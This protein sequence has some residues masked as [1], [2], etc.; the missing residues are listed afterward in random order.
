MKAISHFLFHSLIVSILLSYRLSNDESQY[1]VMAFMSVPNM[2]NPSIWNKETSGIGSSRGIFWNPLKAEETGSGGD[3]NNEKNNEA[4]YRANETQQKEQEM[5]TAEVKRKL[6]LEQKMRSKEVKKKEIEVQ[7]WRTKEQ[8]IRELKEQR[9]IEIKRLKFQLTALQESLAKT[10]K[11]AKE[12]KIQYDKLKKN[13]SAKESTDREI[14]DELQKKFAREEELLKSQIKV[15]E[16]DVMDSNSRFEKSESSFRKKE[17][18]LKSEID[19]LQGL[20]DKINRQFSEA[21]AKLLSQKQDFEGKLSKQ[22]EDAD[23]KTKAFETASGMDKRG[24]R[25]E[26]WEA[27]NKLEVVKYELNVANRDMK[28][29]R[30]TSEA[31]EKQVNEMNKEFQDKLFELETRM[32]GDQMSFAKA[33]KAAEENLESVKAEFKTKLRNKDKEFGDKLNNT[34]LEYEQKLEEMNETLSSQTE[35]IKKLKDDEIARITSETAA[36]ITAQE[37]EF[38]FYKEK[39]EETLFEEKARSEKEVADLKNEMERK[40]EWVKKTA[41]IEKQ[42]IIEEKDAII[43]SNQDQATRVFIKMESE[44]NQR[45]MEEASVRKRADESILKKNKQINNYEGERKSFRKIAKLALSLAKE[46][47]VNFIS[48]KKKKKS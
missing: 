4:V 26:A 3:A 45:W 16:G 5:I 2:K 24:L 21:S 30:S 40:L 32:E 22:K 14:I 10:E 39:S 20:I 13:S 44:L 25:Y 15:L 1:G 31:L 33:Q 35:E 7:E 36:Q 41:E 38:Q 43:S 42:K 19:G 12:A 28:K 23:R 18:E 48:K 46:K 29:Y 47:S 34:T 11:R 6:V 37:E 17:T 27:L 8:E 9:E